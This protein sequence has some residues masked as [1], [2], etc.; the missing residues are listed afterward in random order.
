MNVDGRLPSRRWTLLLVVLLALTILVLLPLLVTKWDWHSRSVLLG[1]L[2]WFGLVP[3]CLGTWLGI[4]SATLLV[5]RGEGTPAP[6]HPPQRFVLAGPYQVVRHP[7]LIGAFAVLLGEALLVESAS[8]L[9]YLGVVVGVARW[10][11]VAAEEPGLQIRFGDAYRV[12]Q[13]YVPRWL[14]R[15]RRT[16]RSE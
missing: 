12:Y 8:I 7:M 1:P 11:V 2:R 6:W 13:Q 5:T 16:S 4:W 14:P 10:Y 15:R 3:I 9:L